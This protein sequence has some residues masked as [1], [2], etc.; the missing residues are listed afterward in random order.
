[1]D[2]LNRT[3][4]LSGFL[5]TGAF[6]IVIGDPLVH[7]MSFEKLFS[8]E[9]TYRN[10][11]AYHNNRSQWHIQDFLEGA[12]TPEVGRQPIIWQNCCQKLHKSERNWY[13]PVAPTPG[14]ANGTGSEF[15]LETSSVQLVHDG[16]LSFLTLPRFDQEPW[17]CPKKMNQELPFHHLSLF[18]LHLGPIYVLTY[19]PF[20]A[21][22]T[23]I[24]FV[25]AT[26]IDGLILLSYP[27]FPQVR[28]E[29]IILKWT[30]M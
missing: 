25:L 1:M 27:N 15:L 21:E 29:K 6:S 23:F 9:Q 26:D 14:Y 10:D 4:C 16:Q 7:S 20:E 24:V 18:S 5:W 2:T 17:D 11:F 3:S 28:S 13:V 19:F 22:L 8:V 30:L 12:P